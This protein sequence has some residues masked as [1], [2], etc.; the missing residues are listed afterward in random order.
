ME[1]KEISIVGDININTLNTSNQ[2]INA[3]SNMLNSFNIVNA[4][5]NPTR[6]TD[7][8]QSLI[9]NFFQEF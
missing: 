5:K 4:V 2:Q 7:H 3:Y 8:S 9:D 6:I 1:N